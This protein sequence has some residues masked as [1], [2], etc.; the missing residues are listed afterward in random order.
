MAREPVKLIFVSR[1]CF[2]KERAVFEIVCPDFFTLLL[3]SSFTQF[4]AYR[5]VDEAF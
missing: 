2:E 5:G 1:V 3:S 4:K